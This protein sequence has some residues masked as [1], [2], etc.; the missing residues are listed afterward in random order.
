M[1]YSEMLREPRYF[2]NYNKV[3]SVI[4]ERHKDVSE[5][6]VLYF[7]DEYTFIELT[8][9]DS[10]KNTIEVYKTDVVLFDETVIK[11]KQ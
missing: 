10:N 5:Y 8:R 9:G 6:K 7:N 1:V 11:I 2:E 4:Q 3:G